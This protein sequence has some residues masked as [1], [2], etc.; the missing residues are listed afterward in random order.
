MLWLQPPGVA[1]AFMAS[2]GGMMGDDDDDDDFD[3]DDLEDM[4]AEFEETFGAGAG[5]AK[6]K[7]GKGSSPPAGKPA[8]SD[9]YATLGLSK[10]CSQS[11][12]K[13]AYFELAKTKHPGTSVTP[14]VNYARSTSLQHT[15]TLTRVILP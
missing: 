1:E 3:E 11:E 14:P 8:K 4:A 6:G 12:I 10:G 5:G 7:S 13:K 15:H 9:H 2:M